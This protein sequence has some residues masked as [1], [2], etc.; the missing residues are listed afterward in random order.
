VNIGVKYSVH[1]LYAIASA[2]FTTYNSKIIIISIFSC[3]KFRRIIFIKTAYV[4]M[5]IINT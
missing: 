5:E 2:K 3:E 4:D 1:E